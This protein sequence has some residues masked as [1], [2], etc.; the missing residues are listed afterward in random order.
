MI[1]KVKDL[2]SKLSKFNQEYDIICY[3]EDEDILD[4]KQGFRLFEIESVDVQ[5]AEK[6]RLN[7][8]PYLKFGKTPSSKPHILISI[9]ADF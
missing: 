2:I 8:T 3:C 7:N 6:V 9:I 1:V 5:D 4:K